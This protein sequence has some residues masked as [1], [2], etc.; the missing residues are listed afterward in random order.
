MWPSS[1]PTTA[2][3]LSEVRQE[4][5]G[6]EL[7]GQSHPVRGIHP[8]VND[9]FFGPDWELMLR[10]RRNVVECFGH[11]TAITCSPAEVIKSPVS[12][13]PPTLTIVVPPPK[14][15]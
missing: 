6:D 4:L 9:V 15:C 1:C 11:T 14:G 10:P 5:D 2:G 13:Q 8:H 12:H 7:L 3:R